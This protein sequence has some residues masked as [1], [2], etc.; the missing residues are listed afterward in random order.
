MKEELIELVRSCDDLVELA[1]AIE[2]IEIAGLQDDETII[3]VISCRLLIIN[4]K[5][6]TN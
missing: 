6:N 2:V 1:N 4:L 5:N 3:T